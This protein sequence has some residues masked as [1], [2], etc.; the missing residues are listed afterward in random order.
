MRINKIEL[1]NF[2]SF[3][4]VT[5]FNSNSN[6]KRNIILIG[7]K[8]GTG[9]TTLFSAI[10]IC[11]YGYR[12]YGYQAVNSF[13]NK[14]IIKSIN[15]TAKTKKPMNAYVAVEL[16]FNNG[17]ECDVYN[18]KRNWIME[19]EYSLQ[20]TLFVRKN[21][22]ALSED[23]INDFENYI[24]HVI[25]PELFNLYFFDGEKIADFFLDDGGNIRVKNAFLTLCGYDTFEIMRKNFK[26]TR[27]TYSNCS[28]G[29]EEYL[30]IKQKVT[31]MENCM[32]NKLHELKSCV[33][34]EEKIEAEILAL[35]HEYSK[36]GGV[37]HDEWNTKLNLVRREE[38]YREEQNAWLKR[39][40]NETIPFIILKDQ[41]LALKQQIENEDRTEK[42][43]NFGDQLDSESIKGLILDILKPDIIDFNIVKFVDKL[44]NRV[45]KDNQYATP[46]L[47]LSQDQK[48]EVLYAL[49]HILTFNISSI[50]KS[51]NNIKLSISK[52]QKIRAD[53]EKCSIEAVNTYV[54]EKNQLLAKKE[55]LIR[56]KAGY[57]E[58][59]RTME[60]ELI[61]DKEVLRKS[62]KAYELELKED[63]IKDISGR[64][65]LFLDV[66]Q[67]ELYRTQ[68]QQVEEAFRRE[69]NSLMRKNNFID[70]III[71]DDFNVKIFRNDKEIDKDTLSNGEKQIFIMALY[72]SLIQLCNHEV[73]F[74]IDTPFARIDTEH[75]RNIAKYF[76]RGLKGQ[77]FILS[78]NEEIESEHINILDDKILAKYILENNDNQRTTVIENAFFEV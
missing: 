70:Y 13:Y 22:V 48:S 41:M 54:K 15:D 62:Q 39:M 37:T 18:L 49:N 6:L 78:T 14:N 34:E 44:K 65:I 47:C 51:K 64:S 36:S 66:L 45:Y 42:L 46:I 31:D 12:V 63:S 76:F 7:G 30:K 21:G 32:E 11:I 53:I 25:P 8:N 20:E 43:K 1:N 2:G 4:G 9:K 74:I 17:Q 16:S 55:T 67:S 71:D 19:D 59:I 68:I 5:I 69:I 29:L 38:L 73:P 40:A 77:V 50:E 72:K 56:Q 28:N 52:S 10:R 61:K 33:L 35:D 75:R 24:L 60:I 27:S 3:E 26:R 23:E 58:L 57:E